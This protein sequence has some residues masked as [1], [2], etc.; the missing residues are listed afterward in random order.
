MRGGRFGIT[1]TVKSH[2]VAWRRRLPPV[3]THR[4]CSPH[5]AS[6]SS[7]SRLHTRTRRQTTRSDVRR[8][9]RTSGT[10]QTAG[11]ALVGSLTSLRVGELEGGRRA[12]CSPAPL[13]RRWPP[14]KAT[15]ARRP[16]CSLRDRTLPRSPM[17]RPPERRD[18]ARI[19]C[20]QPERQSA[21]ST[22]ER[23]RRVGNDRARRATRD[24]SQ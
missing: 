10:V 23:A 16:A 15:R 3:P 5:S 9:D 2:P 13:A 18:S 1:V 14:P 19:A 17:L 8:R 22:A 4:P 12:R 11:T 20:L 6:R 7:K 24:M 21:A